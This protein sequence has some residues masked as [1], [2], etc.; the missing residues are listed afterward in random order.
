[1]SEATSS[2]PPISVADAADDLKIDELELELRAQTAPMVNLMPSSR[3]STSRAS[4]RASSTFED[5]RP[6]G[7]IVDPLAGLISHD[8]ISDGKLK[9]KRALSPSQANLAAE[10]ANPSF[11][12]PTE[13]YV[14]SIRRDVRWIFRTNLIL[15]LLHAFVTGLIFSMGYTKG[16]NETDY[17]SPTV[18]LCAFGCLHTCVFIFVSSFQVLKQRQSIDSGA[19][20]V[21]NW[22]WFDSQL[23]FSLAQS[24]ELIL[25]LFPGLVVFILHEKGNS[26]QSLMSNFPNQTLKGTIIAHIIIAILM[27]LQ[28]LFS[29]LHV[30]AKLRLLQEPRRLKEEEENKLVTVQEQKT[31]RLTEIA[32]NN[33]QLALDARSLSTLSILTSVD[34]EMDD[35][36]GETVVDKPFPTSIPITRAENFL[37]FTNLCTNLAF[38]AMLL[39]VAIR[40][41]NS[42]PIV[43]LVLF[44][45][46]LIFMLADAVRMKKLGEMSEKWLTNMRLI[47]AFHLYCCYCFF[48]V[49][50]GIQFAAGYY[51]ESFGTILAQ[52][53][54]SVRF[55]CFMIMVL[56]A[57][58]C[59][60]Y[61]FLTLLLARSMRKLDEIQQVKHNIRRNSQLERRN[62]QIKL[63]EEKE[64][65]KQQT[66]HET[67]AERSEPVSRN[68]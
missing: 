36:S 32:Q 39:T 56:F 43:C 46:L 64:K 25:F 33:P 58:V 4:K 29:I 12:N 24:F 22:S 48:W 55:Q 35:G 5:Q 37:L 65:Q 8:S 68:Q 11:N 52:F 42:G 17:Y 27:F 51:G 7:L 57:A 44:A 3:S 23:L 61:P 20:I 62:S 6:A 34:D 38:G 26:F 40:T 54:P 10:L 50:L 67:I 31:K 16:S 45:P 18:V 30:S 41:S 53:S 59:C 60:F 21:P 13:K 2:S 19:Q 15:C 49:A 14:L 9:P 1:M 66:I 47:L 63:L 28:D